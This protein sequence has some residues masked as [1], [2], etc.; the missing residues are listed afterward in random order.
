MG[1]CKRYIAI[2]KILFKESLLFITSIVRFIIYIYMQN[3]MTIINNKKEVETEYSKV[4]KG[5]PGGA[6]GKEPACQCRRHKRYGF[7]PWVGKIPWRRAWQLT[8]VHLPGESHRQRRLEA[9]V[10]RVV[11]SQ[12][13]PK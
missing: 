4:V 6:S 1:K 3:S 7:D 8:P 9:I 2:L 12:I 5:F 10:H 13:Q 11:K